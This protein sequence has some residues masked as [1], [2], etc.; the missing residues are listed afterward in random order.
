MD[1][2]LIQLN[3]VTYS[4][5]GT[6]LDLYPCMIHNLSSAEQFTVPAESVVG[7]YSNVLAQLLYTNTDN[8]LTTYQFR[9]NQS[10]VTV[11]NNDDDADYNIAIKVHLGKYSNKSL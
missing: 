10:S 9:G 11:A 2:L 5:N 1:Y 8:S 4:P 3:N 6:P 7:L